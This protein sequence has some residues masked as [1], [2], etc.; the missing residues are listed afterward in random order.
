MIYDAVIPYDAQGFFAGVLER[1]RRRLDELGAKRV[2]VGRRWY[3]IL[4]EPYT[5]GEEIVIE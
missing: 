5:P 3:W 1:L 2:R 4:K